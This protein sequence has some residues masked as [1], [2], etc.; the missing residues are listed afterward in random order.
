[1]SALP[2]HIGAARRDPLHAKPSLAGVPG[3]SVAA[4]TSHGPSSQPQNTNGLA[5]TPIASPPANG[6]ARRDTASKPPAMA[7]TGVP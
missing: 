7:R 5:A 3:Q 1:V 6:R 4:S 2:R